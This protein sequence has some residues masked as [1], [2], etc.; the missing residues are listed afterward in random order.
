VDGSLGDDLGTVTELATKLGSMESALALVRDLG[1]PVRQGAYSRRLLMERLEMPEVPERG[2]EPI[3][4]LAEQLRPFGISVLDH[5]VGRPT[6]VQ[7]IAKTGTVRFGY[8][9][10]DEPLLTPI[11]IS[12]TEPIAARVYTATKRIRGKAGFTLSGFFDDAPV[13]LYFC[14]LHSERRA[15]GFTAGEL[16]FI[17][18]WLSRRSRPEDEY[19]DELVRKFVLVSGRPNVLRAA[20]PIRTSGDWELAARL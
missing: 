13:P 9:A 15:W 5:R 8:D 2:P 19:E 16:R 6:M 18:G 3:A 10:P 12:S 17:H 14:L 4:L 11:T 20:F 7:L 1:V